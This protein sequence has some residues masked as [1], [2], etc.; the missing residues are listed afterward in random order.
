[1]SLALLLSNR[2]A[3]DVVSLLERLALSGSSGGSSYE[4]VGTYEPRAHG[5][6]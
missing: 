5:E 6:G 3:E 4:E 2:N 1:M